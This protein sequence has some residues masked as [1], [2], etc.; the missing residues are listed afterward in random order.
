MCACT[1]ESQCCILEIN[2]TLEINY[3]SIKEMVFFKYLLNSRV[4]VCVCVCVYIYIYIYIYIP[5]RN[6]TLEFSIFEIE[7]YDHLYAD[8][9]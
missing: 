6:H 7:H 8:K 5:L 1:A 3:T 2:T 9:M 4:C